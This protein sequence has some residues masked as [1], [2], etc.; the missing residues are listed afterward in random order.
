MK[1]NYKI[2]LALFA[3]AAMGGAAVTAFTPKENRLPMWLERLT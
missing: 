2:A 1:S 3:G